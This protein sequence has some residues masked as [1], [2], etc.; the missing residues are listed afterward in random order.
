MLKI[1]LST[2][3]LY[4][5]E[6]DN[7]TLGAIWE[8]W[9]R[10]FDGKWTNSETY[11]QYSKSCKK[12]VSELRA[13]LSTTQLTAQDKQNKDDF[14][15]ELAKFFFFPKTKENPQVNYTFL[16]LEEICRE[17]AELEDFKTI[18]KIN[19]ML[20]KKNIL[21]QFF[22][23]YMISIDNNMIMSTQLS[24]ALLLIVDAQLRKTIKPYMGAI[25]AYKRHKS[26]LLKH[27]TNALIALVLDVALINKSIK[28]YDEAIAAIKSMDILNPEDL[29]YLHSIKQYL[30]SLDKKMSEE[31][32][33][34]AFSSVTNAIMWLGAKINQ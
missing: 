1:N 20:L 32:R 6:I 19:N 28:T 23:N 16:I 24:G 17:L 21:M 33:H 10:S 3:V 9:F 2:M 27:C 22:G 18:G 5:Y 31:D 12:I 26:S 4:Y 34:F 7:E 13:K 25:S 29:K 15:Y 8:I 14:T 11:N 30:T